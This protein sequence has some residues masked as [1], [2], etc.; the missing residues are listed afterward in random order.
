MRGL[1]E[2]WLAVATASAVLLLLAACGTEPAGQ[3]LGAGEFG[4]S[5]L[6]NSRVMRSASGGVL[7]LGQ[8]FAAEVPTTITFDYDS[9]RLSSEAMAAL[10]RQA[11]WIGDYPQVRFRIYGHTDLVGSNAYNQALGL[12]RARAAVSYLATQGISSSRLDAVVSYGKT[13]PLIRVSGPDSRNRR[14]VTEVS[15]FLSRDPTA[16]D[17]QYAEVLRREYL[18]GAAREHPGNTSVTT[19]VNPE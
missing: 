16:L 6:D 9:A 1:Y 11:A 5:T 18:A 3:D 2:P 19:Q 8:R 15:G 14:T 7:E 4:R 10:R 12:Q 13:R 17:G